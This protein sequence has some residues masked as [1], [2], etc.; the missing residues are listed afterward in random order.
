MD[1][2]STMLLVYPCTSHDDNFE[3]VS[4]C[5]G[6]CMK[7]STASISTIFRIRNPAT[8]QVLYLP[9]PPPYTASVD[10]AFNLSTGE[11]KVICFYCEKPFIN[12]DAAFGLKVITIGK[13]E[14]WRSLQL[15]DGNKLRKKSV[16]R[17][18]YTRVNEVEGNCH[19]VQIIRFT[20]EKED[21]YIEVQT[22][23]IWSEHFTTNTL[24]EGVSLDW[25]EVHVVRWN[26]CLSVGYTK[27]ESLD[28]WVLQDYKEQKWSPNKIIIPVKGPKKNDGRPMFAKDIA[29]I[30][31][32][33]IDL[34]ISDE[35]EYRLSQVMK[36]EIRTETGEIIHKP[37][38]ISF[39][40]IMMAGNGYHPFTLRMKENRAVQ[41]HGYDVAVCLQ[42]HISL[43]I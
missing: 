3:F 8:H 22:L 12:V 42:N 31:F 20:E 18:Y 36:E 41:I 34:H 13:D 40:G 24:P 11:C 33:R 30:F 32:Y 25:K 37:S 19:L 35:G 4:S 29:E 15:P 17:G 26:N 5:A 2:T 1:R 43:F 28:L 7:K 27:E 10:F 14:Q 16:F 6:L 38:L 39:K 23:D 21:M 9:D